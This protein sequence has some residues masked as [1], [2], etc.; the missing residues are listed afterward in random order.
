MLT[1]SRNPYIPSV[2]HLDLSCA[3]MRDLGFRMNLLKL[4]IVSVSLQCEEL[5]LGFVQS[6][7]FD[8]L[9]TNSRVIFLF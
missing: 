7:W 3:E 2:K 1:E 4:L 6:H 5:D 9:S 8:V